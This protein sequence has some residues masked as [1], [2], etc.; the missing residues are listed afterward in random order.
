MSLIQ[1]ARC[2]GH[3]I[4]ETRKLHNSIISKTHKEIRA[5]QLLPR[6]LVNI[7]LDF[8]IDVLAMPLAYCCEF[9]ENDTDQAPRLIKRL[10]RF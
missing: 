8:V 5:F 4:T 9:H 7:L 6:C 1:D 3:C 10:E 2:C